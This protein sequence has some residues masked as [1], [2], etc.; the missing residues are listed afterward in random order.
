MGVNRPEKGFRAWRWN[1]NKLLGWSLGR[2]L[3]NFRLDWYYYVDQKNKK[4]KGSLAE[5]AYLSIRARIL[6]GDLTMGTAISRRKLAAEYGV[7]F[8]PIMEA[9]QRLETEGLVESKPRVGTR[10]RV[11]TPLDIREQLVVREALECQ[12]ARLFAEKASSSER[13]ELTKLAIQLD[14]LDVTL[15]EHPEY[16]AEDLRMRHKLHLHFHA[17][18]VESTGCTALGRII[19]WNQTLVFK[20]L[21]DTAYK[22]TLQSRGRHQK[23]AEVVVGTDADEAEKAM[24]LHVRCGLEAILEALVPSMGENGGIAPLGEAQEHMISRRLKR[25]ASN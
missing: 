1:I 6:H 2:V 15:S 13:K 4:L 24:R 10:V 11:P 19:E 25:S 17:R 3:P 21:F 8:V 14:E 20:W 23:L 7:S 5:Q 16:R 9:L 12:A 18:L 22:K